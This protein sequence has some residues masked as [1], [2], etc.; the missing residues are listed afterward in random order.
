VAWCTVSQGQGSLNTELSVIESK[1][2]DDVREKN[3]VNDEIG[4]DPDLPTN[5]N[6]DRIEE[7]SVPGPVMPN[8][9]VGIQ[10]APEGPPQTIPP[11]PGF[12]SSTGQ[13]GGID[14]PTKAGTGGLY[15]TAGGLGGPRLVSGGFGGRSGAT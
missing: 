11:P 12:G 8:E 7:V 6:I 13:G 4:N 5:Y 1:V 3:L 2:D 15:G 14:D 9:A 10:N